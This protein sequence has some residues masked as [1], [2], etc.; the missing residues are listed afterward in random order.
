[1]QRL[2]VYKLLEQFYI[3]IKVNHM[4]V[5]SHKDINR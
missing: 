5:Y 2:K 4:Y 1:M 3:N